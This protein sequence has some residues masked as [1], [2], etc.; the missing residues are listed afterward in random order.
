[1]RIAPFS[2]PGVNV[3]TSEEFFD[4]WL[5]SGVTR[6]VMLERLRLES[7]GTAKGEGYDVYVDTLL[8]SD[9]SG[10][11]GTMLIKLRRRDTEWRVAGL[12]VL[13]TVRGLYRLSLD[14]DRQFTI[15]NFALSAEDFVLRV[16]SGIAFVAETDAGITGIVI[17]GQGV[18]TFSPAPASEKAQVRIYSGAGSHEGRF[19]S[20]YLRAHPA[21][22]D[23]LLDVRQL[24]GARAGPARAPA[25][26]GG[27]S[28]ECDEVIRP[29]SR[30]SQPRDLVGPP[31][32]GRSCGG[33]AGRQD[34]SGVL[35]VG[36]GT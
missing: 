23:R 5:R 3:N 12:N 28:G 21:E 29:R 18:M 36:H 17:L 2:L 13:T 15:T 24:R 35:E 25:R 32:G 26:R 20:L 10:Q 6:A 19:T 16:P 14:P 33:N 9:K 8:E 7:A 22:F 1:M 27:L 31:E 30:R 34:P 11:V 4:S